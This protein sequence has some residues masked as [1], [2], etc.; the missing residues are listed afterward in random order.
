MAKK[1]KKAAKKPAKKVA[2]KAAPK[3]VE[4]IP[5]NQP[6]LVPYLS[7]KDAQRAVDFYK[8]VL[9]AKVRSMM[10]APDG[11][12]AHCSLQIGNAVLMLA[13]QMD[14]GQP[15]TAGRSSGVM[16][17]VKDAHAVFDK[18]VSLGAKTLMPVTDMFWGDRWG[19]LEDPFGNVW[20][21]ATH[22]ED[23]KPAERQKRAMQAMSQPP[24]GID[25]G[26]PPPPPP[27]AL[28]QENLAQ[29]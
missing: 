9:G 27:D 19:M 10:S 13:D 29:A 25:A 7:V 20:Q 23:V 17:Y 6:Q 22:I 4:P 2:A 8:Q 14:M 1:M 28:T 12:I 16:L 24:P 18:A 11:K 21:I 5:K 26:T 3:R 15:V